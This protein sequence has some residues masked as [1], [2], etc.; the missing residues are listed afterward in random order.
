MNGGSCQAL[1]GNYTCTCSE[2][3]DGAHCEHNID[4]CLRNPCENGGTC[5][6][7][8][9]DYNCNCTSKFMGKNCDQPYDPC[10]KHGGQC[11]N[12]GQCKHKTVTSGSTSASQDGVPSDFYCECPVGFN[13]FFCQIN[14]DDCDGIECPQGTT[15]IDRIGT[16]EC[17]NSID[18]VDCASNPCQNNG[19]C[20]DANNGYR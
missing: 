10:I 4:D 14:I 18:L 20:L 15:C 16:Y 1:E 11:K 9:N 8:L 2:G 12:G 7:G 19:Q 3:F 13:G 6:D 17:Q 5:Y